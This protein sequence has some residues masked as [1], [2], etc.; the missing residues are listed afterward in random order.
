MSLHR[1]PKYRHYKP[2]NL[3]MVMIKGHAHYLGRYDSPESWERYHRLIADLHAGRQA[4]SPDLASP[5]NGLA[6]TINELILAYVKFADSYY[7]K[8][9]HPTIEPGNIRL[10]LRLVRRL[11]GS[12]PA[13]SFGP[14]A[15]KTIRDEMIKAGNCRTE[16]NRRVGRIVRM[17][18]WGVSEELVHPFVYESLRTVSGLRE[19]RSAARESQP[20]RP[21]SEEMVMAIRPFV[22]RQVW[23]MIELQ[24]LTGM[25]PGE[26]VLMRTSD[27]EMTGDVWSYIP[28]RH[29]TEHHGKKRE[30]LLGPRASDILRPWLKS[31]PCVY[32][33]SPI[34]AM[35]ERQEQRR[36]QRKTRVQ[37]SQ[38][39]R[40]KPRPKRLPGARYT[41]GSYRK[42]IQVACGK[43]GIS[44]WHPHQLRHTAATEIRKRFGIEATRIILGHEDV[45]TAQIY[46]E[47]DRSRGVEIM[48]LVG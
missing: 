46:A 37:P 23:A 21:V 15:L 16:I 10:V 17:F 7:V 39:N 34:D 29:K 24:R 44:K 13:G 8:D 5:D 3:G 32:L 40:R 36:L 12:T 22:N 28:H 26:V 4:S 48:R 35:A 43:A 25:R 31:D 27:L 18:K 30:V 19:G 20:V 38:R 6:L 11:W 33:F 41:V 42:A 2:K 45:R 14:L 47:E 1:V 9:G